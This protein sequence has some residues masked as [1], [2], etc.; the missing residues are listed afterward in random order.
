MY[1]RKTGKDIEIYIMEWSEIIE[2][3]R[4]KLG[5]LST[6]LNIKDRT[7]RDKFEQEYSSIF[8]E[9]ISARLTKIK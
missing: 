6:S 7:I 8:N 2:M 4:R 9:K 3:N 1:E 5:Y